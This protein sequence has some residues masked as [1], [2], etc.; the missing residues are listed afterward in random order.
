MIIIMSIDKWIQEW[1]ITILLLA[2]MGGVEVLYSSH[3]YSHVYESGL[4]PEPDPTPAW[5]YHQ[6]PA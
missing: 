2:M 1:H 6:G 5:P 3:T 4:K